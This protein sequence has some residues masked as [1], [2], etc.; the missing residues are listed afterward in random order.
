LQQPVG[1][2]GAAEAENNN[3]PA[4]EQEPNV[5]EAAQNPEVEREAVENVEQPQVNPEEAD[6]VRQRR[7]DNLGDAPLPP[8]PIEAPSVFML[9]WTFVSSFFASLIPDRPNVV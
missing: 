1:V 8:P 6:G 3:Q 5:T 4:R 9:T 7:Q 2:G